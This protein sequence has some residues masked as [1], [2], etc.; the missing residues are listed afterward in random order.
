MVKIK[1]NMEGKFPPHFIKFEIDPN[2][3]KNI[4]LL[5]KNDLIEVEGK[6]KSIDGRD[7]EI[8]DIN[9]ISWSSKK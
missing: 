6:I 7:M 3:F 1:Y 2:K 5:S 4:A 8:C 9:I